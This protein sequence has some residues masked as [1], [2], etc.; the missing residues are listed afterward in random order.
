MKVKIYQ[1]EWFPVY[2]LDEI[3]EFTS[4]AYP[5][6]D[7]PDELYYKYKIFEEMYSD[8]QSQIEPYYKRPNYKDF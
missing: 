2:E 8:L 4:K 1:S 7:L 5:E 3:T 6:I